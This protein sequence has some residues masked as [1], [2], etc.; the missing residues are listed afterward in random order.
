MHTRA[1]RQ[2]PDGADGQLVLPEKLYAQVTPPVIVVTA[3]CD[4]PSITGHALLPPAVV[5]SSQPATNITVIKATATHKI[6][7]FIQDYTICHT[8]SA[9]PRNYYQEQRGAFL[10][11]QSQVAVPPT[12]WVHSWVFAQNPDGAGGQLVAP[13]KVYAQVTT[14]TAP[15][16]IA[17]V[18][19]ITGHESLAVVFSS[20][21]TKNITVIKATATHKIKFFIQDYTICHT[22]SATPFWRFVKK[23]MD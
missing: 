20:Q 18:P 11:V 16:V 23:T 7:F 13:E 9:T 21:P 12:G 10:Y 6:K 2:N 15:N 17:A 1:L 22:V 8:V 3:P 5:F 4:I 14:P 19:S